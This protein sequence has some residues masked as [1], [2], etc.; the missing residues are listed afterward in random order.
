MD[1][2][3]SVYCNVFNLVCDFAFHLP[4]LN[5]AR[6][7]MDHYKFIPCNY[8]IWFSPLDERGAIPN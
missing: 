3:S 1:E 6:Y 4:Q 8:H 2:P 5:G 7:G